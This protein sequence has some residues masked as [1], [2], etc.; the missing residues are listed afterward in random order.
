MIFNTIKQVM[1]TL[2]PIIRRYAEEIQNSNLIRIESRLWNNYR[3]ARPETENNI[4]IRDFLL[5]PEVEK[6]MEK[7]KALSEREFIMHPSR[8]RRISR[9]INRQNII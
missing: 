7:M 9:V 6:E 2:S 8:I 1:S 5:L 3:N 4:Q